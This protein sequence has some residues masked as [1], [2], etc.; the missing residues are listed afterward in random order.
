MLF[1]AMNFPV[2]PVLH[3]IETVSSLGFDYVELTMDPPQAHFE[4][5]RENMTEIQR[6]LDFHRMG[7]VCHLPSFVSTA[8]LTKSL[9]EASLTEVLQ[10]L[11][12]AR[13]LN[14]SKVVLHPSYMVGLSLFVKDKA[15]GY[16]MESL[17]AV[18]E[19]ADK[20]GL[21]VCIENLFPRSH[22]PGEPEEFDEIFH[23]FPSLKLTL[24][25]GHAHIE[26][27]DGQRAADFID[28]F[29]GRL[30]HIHAS[31]NL[32]KED[33]HLPVGTGS[34][35]FHKIAQAL[36]AVRYDD[37]ITLEIFSRDRDY[38]KIS[39]EKLEAIFAS[40]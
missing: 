35:D 32:G 36:K 22:A 40:V 5:I 11:Q 24:D 34:V 27:R 16:A 38:L 12:V 37:T 19:K 3:E 29:S 10:S 17:Q 8:D 1:G 13:D 9:R 14:A 7:L 2:R 26:D 21:T 6:A 39:R 20:L 23:C 33:N 30:A 31:D 28:R 25:T 18:V 15:K 4:V